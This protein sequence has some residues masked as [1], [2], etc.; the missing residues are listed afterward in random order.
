VALGQVFSG[1]FRFPCQL[2]FHQ[3]LHIHHHLSSWAG[4]IGQ[5][6][7]GVTS[8]L[9]PTPL[10]QVRKQN[11]NKLWEELITYFPFIL[12]VPHRKRFLKQYFIAAGISPNNDRVIHRNRH[13]S[14]NSCSVASIFFTTGTCLSGLCLAMKGGIYFTEPLPS[15]GRRHTHTHRLIGEGDS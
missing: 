4:T 3:M 7:A 13:V 6:V 8:G 14:H 15:N 10:Q 2:S 9:N 5:L 12:H 1:C 11:K